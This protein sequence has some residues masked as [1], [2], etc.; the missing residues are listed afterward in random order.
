MKSTARLSDFAARL[1]RVIRASTRRGPARARTPLG[2]E[3]ETEPRP[4][5][6]CLAEAKFNSLALELFRLQFEQ[7]AP[8]RRICQARGVSP[9]DATDWSHIPAVPAAAFK[10]FELSCLPPEERTAVFCS[11]GTTGQR[12]G[13]HFHNEESLALYRASLTPWFEANVL[14]GGCGMDDWQLSVLTPG[15]E[16]APHSSLVHMFE[17]VRRQLGSP[18]SAFLGQAVADGAWRLDLEAAVAALRS[19]VRSG[20]P[21]LLLG[22]AFMFVSL[23][24]HLATQGLQFALPPRSRL[25]ETGGYKGRS[26]AL[27]AEEL[28]ALITGRLGIAPALIIREYG[29][30][31]LGS[32]A[33][34][35]PPG[36]ARPFRF[37]G[38]VR[39]QIISPETGQ[40]VTEGQTGLIRVFDLANAFSVLAVQTEDLAVRCADGFEL[41]GRAALAEPRGCS[42]MALTE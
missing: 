40:E 36:S 30:S 13:R 14:D 33:Y 23:L 11:S 6:A 7:N 4:S 15:P 25:M 35:G 38:W 17:A 16:A 32:Q 5:R 27:P 18:A 9:E 34:A 21:L 12:P 29:M 3:S 26:R 10:E 42:L 2:A 31:E 24:D 20:R 1:R 22:T 19:S 39:V 41:L 28:R 37:P 8:Y